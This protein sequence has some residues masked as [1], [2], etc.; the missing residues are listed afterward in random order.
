MNNQHCQPESQTPGVPKVIN[1]VA[2]L[3]RD[4]L[5]ETITPK[6]Q[7]NDLKHYS[8]DM[9]NRFMSEECYEYSH[10]SRLF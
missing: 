6:N 7:T 1:N 8:S 4:D 2:F 3:L 9:K 10:I 5:K